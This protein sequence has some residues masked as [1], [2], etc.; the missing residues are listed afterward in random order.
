MNRELFKDIKFCSRFSFNLKYNV[1]S[2][3]SLGHKCLI[4]ESP[5]RFFIS[6]SFN[7]EITARA[8]DSQI[9][10]SEMYLLIT[11]NSDSSI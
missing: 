6:F 1:L 10:L 5:R 7:S 2:F 4:K 9:N 8:L 3:I 11:F